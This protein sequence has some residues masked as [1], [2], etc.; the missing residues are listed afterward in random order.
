MDHG[1]VNEGFGRLRVDVVVRAQPAA[2]P[3]ASR[4]CAPPP[5]A[6]LDLEPALVLRL[7]HHHLVPPV[8]RARLVHARGNALIHPRDRHA[9]AGRH[10]YSIRIPQFVP[11]LHPRTQHIHAQQQSIGV[12]HDELRDALDLLAAVVT[13]IPPLL[14]WSSPTGSR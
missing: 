4:R 14:P 9:W 7:A 12:D 6:G 13:D 2:M 5:T 10:R 1:E 8:Q 11:V 3:L